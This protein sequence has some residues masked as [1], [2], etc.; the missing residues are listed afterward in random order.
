MPTFES[1]NFEKSIL[2]PHSAGEVYVC[3]DKVVLPDTIVTDDIVKMGHLPADCI[4]IDL[5]IRTEELDSNATDTLRFTVGLLNDAGDDLVSG[6]ELLV[7][8][9]AEAV[10]T[11]RG[12]G[13]GF[14]SITRDKVNDRILA[15]KVTA[16]AA[17]AVSGTIRAAMIYRA[18]DY[19]A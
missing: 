1:N 17:T 12:D 9:Q 4:P 5:I 19:G 8:A 16:T 14:L 6:S 18:S 2:S 7:G 10:K 15:I 13:A 11:I 3:D